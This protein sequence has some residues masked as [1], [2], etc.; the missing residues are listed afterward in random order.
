MDVLRSGQKKLYFTK[1]FKQF[2][3]L[4]TKIKLKMFDKSVK[5]KLGKNTN[6]KVLPKKFKW[7]RKL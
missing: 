7:T 4:N 3:L 1:F 5:K 2:F 6:N